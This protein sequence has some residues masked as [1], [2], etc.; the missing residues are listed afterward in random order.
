LQDTSRL[1]IAEHCQ[2]YNRAA[3][4]FESVMMCGRF[5]LIDLAED[6]GAMWKRSFAPWKKSRRQH[7]DICG[8][9]QLRPW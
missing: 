4:E 7:L 1:A 9:G 3:R 5:V 6:R 2:E 8:E